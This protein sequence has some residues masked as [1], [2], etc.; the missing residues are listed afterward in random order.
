MM[1]DFPALLSL[2]ARMLVVDAQYALK[3]KV[4][5]D[6]VDFAAA[7]C[8]AAAEGQDRS[9]KFATGNGTE[10]YSKKYKVETAPKLGM[11]ANKLMYSSSETSMLFSK[12]TLWLG[13]K[14]A[15][16][17]EAMREIQRETQSTLCNVSVI[18]A[19]LPEACRVLDEEL[20]AEMV[21]HLPEMM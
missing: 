10:Q 6:E 4:A 9:R 20:A 1:G 18:R 19:A 11:P 12:F 13:P 15:G 7:D 14:S 16:L 5:T 8:K 2:R 17:T 21:G 3:R